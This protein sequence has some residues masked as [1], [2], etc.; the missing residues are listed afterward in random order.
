VASEKIMG[1]RVSVIAATLL[2]LG[3]AW[4][5]TAATQPHATGAPGTPKP[6]NAQASQESALINQVNAATAAGKWQDVVNALAKLIT[7]NP[8]WDYY[9][10]L[11][12]AQ[13]NLRQ[14]KESLAAFD[15]GLAA[16]LAD[17]TTPAD[18]LKEARA[19][20]LTDEGNALLKLKR[21]DE[22]L[23]AFNT[24]ATLSAHPAMAYLDV[25]STQYNMG[26][27]SVDACDKAIAADPTLA[28]AYFI[29][30][31]ILYGTGTMDQSNNLVV[32]AGTA[33]AFKQYLALA[34]KG[35]HAADVQKIL[36]TLKKPT[37]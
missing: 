13:F 19:Q 18:Q 22:A 23:L 24:A 27:T 32:P 4:H 16:A 29:K 25:C 12:S 36:D 21:R 1:V 17:K 15:K 28:D 8:R 33:E 11:G 10:A 7:L 34:P 14:Y 6:P 5:A 3:A 31:A 26:I 37:K 20:M 30:G 9:Q 2:G 35:A